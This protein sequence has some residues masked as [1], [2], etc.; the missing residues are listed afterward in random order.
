MLREE[1][2][3]VFRAYREGV[4]ADEVEV[5]NARGGAE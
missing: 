5:D 4:D 3:A 1:A 2:L